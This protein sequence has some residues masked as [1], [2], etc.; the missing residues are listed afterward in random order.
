[1]GVRI[2]L[3]ALT[4]GVKMHSVK[5]IVKG[6][7]AE[8]SHL[9]NG[10]AYYSVQVEQLTYTFPV[11]LNDVN[12]ATLLKADKAIFFMRW[13]KKAIESQEMRIEAIKN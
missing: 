5:D 2:P 4:I 12:D 8:F 11:P 3:G 13:I 7:Q 10:C 1:M 9:V 6:N